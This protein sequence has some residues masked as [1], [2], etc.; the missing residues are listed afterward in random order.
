MESPVQRVTRPCFWCS[1]RGSRGIS[2]SMRPRM[3]GTPSLG[4]HL[5][6]LSTAWGVMALKAI[7]GRHGKPG[8]CPKK[9]PDKRHITISKWGGA[10]KAL[11]IGRPGAE[12]RQRT[13]I[14]LA[15]CK[16]DGAI[17]GASFG[18]QQ[19]ASRALRVHLP[20]NW[21]SCTAR[22]WRTATSL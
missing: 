5:Q 19:K 13:S 10:P 6:K 18:K 3:T 16:L 15:I 21:N 2:S 14:S 4:L 17:G 1:A 9:A 8:Q 7:L 22:A 12:I 11:L 20:L